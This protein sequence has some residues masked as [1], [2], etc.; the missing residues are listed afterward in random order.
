MKRKAEAESMFVAVVVAQGG[1]PSRSLDG[2]WS[3]F[4][5]PVKGDAIAK[6]VAAKQKWEGRGYGP[7]IVLAGELVESIT[8]TLHYKVR[9][10]QPSPKRK[11]K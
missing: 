3:C 2:S 8:S 11:G 1:L 7:Y 5:E 9:R 4:I 10:L 6:A